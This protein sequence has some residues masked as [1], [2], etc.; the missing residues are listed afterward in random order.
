MK[1][2]FTLPILETD[3][4]D[5]LV[6]SIWALTIAEFRSIVESDKRKDKKIAVATLLYIGICEDYSSWG[7]KLPE[8]KLLEYARRHSGITKLK[9]DW[10]PNNSIRLARERYKDLQSF[11]A[12]EVQMLFAAE[13]SIQ[14][15]TRLI[16]RITGEAERITEKSELNEH[17][18]ENVMDLINEIL[19]KTDKLSDRLDTLKK[20]QDKVSTLRR[21]ERIEK[22]RGGGAAGPKERPENS[23]IIK[24]MK[25]NGQES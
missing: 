2:D 3:E 22:I 9:K 21:Q 6:I 19:R 5:N 8:H 14:A 17:N 12:V 24:D 1:F 11:C 18:V 10:V 13:K 7:L 16:V 20:L 25:H 15:L 23:V 4:E